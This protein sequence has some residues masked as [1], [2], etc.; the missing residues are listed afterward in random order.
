MPFTNRFTV[1]A[2]E[3]QLGAC[4]LAQP[5]IGLANLVISA[6]AHFTVGSDDDA[7]VEA[8]V[9]EHIALAVRCKGAARCRLGR[10]GRKCMTLDCGS[11][12]VEPLLRVARDATSGELES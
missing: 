11:A 10:R 3:D 4:R 9:L 5:S 1:G 6:N 7:L 12:L 8:L 2:A